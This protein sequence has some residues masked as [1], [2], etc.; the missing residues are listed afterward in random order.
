MSK[1]VLS[2]L[3]PFLSVILFIATLFSL[4]FLKMEVRRQGYSLWKE[5]KQYNQLQDQYRMM[6]MRYARLTRPDHV[7]TYALSRLTLNE[8]H[9]GQIIQLTG[10]HIALPQ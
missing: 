8:A 2:E 6:S 7:K 9:R 3:K 10:S 5:S 1:Q 4:A